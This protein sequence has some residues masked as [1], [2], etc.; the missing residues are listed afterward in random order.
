MADNI[1]IDLIKNRNEFLLRNFFFENFIY[2]IINSITYDDICYLLKLEEC[3]IQLFKFQN[4]SLLWKK[5]SVSIIMNFDIENF[6]KNIKLFYKNNKCLG[7]NEWNF[8]LNELFANENNLNKIESTFMNIFIPNKIDFY[9]DKNILMELIRKKNDK[10]IKE[11]I[12]CSREYVYRLLFN[13]NFNVINEFEYFYSNFKNAIDYDNLVLI[14]FNLF[15][16]YE[17]DNDSIKILTRERIIKLFQEN[18]LQNRDYAQH[19]IKKCNIYIYSQTNLI[20]LLKFIQHHINEIEIDNILINRI[21]EYFYIVID[22]NNNIE[23]NLIDIFI[24][25]DILWINII[26]KILLIPNILNSIIF[27]TKFLEKLPAYNLIIIDFLK[28]IFQKNEIANINV[29]I[30]KIF[31]QY[32][33]TYEY[34]TNNYEYSINLINDIFNISNYELKTYLMIDTIFKMKS[35]LIIFLI[36]YDKQKKILKLLKKKIIFFLQN[37]TE[38]TNNILDNLFIFNCVKQFYISNLELFCNNQEE[39]IENKSFS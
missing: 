15:A 26:K 6:E 14:Y 9:I 27:V 12:F 17:Q 7:Y 29:D 24:Q 8:I 18:I 5:I 10:Y 2:D 1:V 32:I 13:Y 22:N 19:L 36:N 38:Y 35:N 21:S 23:D 37:N 30:Y 3:V 33:H 39:N 11:I 28:E 4:D 34:Q 31:Y 25:F 16:E 20:G